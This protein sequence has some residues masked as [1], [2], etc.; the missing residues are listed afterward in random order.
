MATV[1][2]SAGIILG[3]GSLLW[4]LKSIE[5]MITILPLLSCLCPTVR[6]DTPWRNHKE[7]DTFYFPPEQIIDFKIN[8]YGKSVP[9]T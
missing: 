2:R 4:L 8:P 1:E 3:Q 6:L 9:L 7:K 5:S